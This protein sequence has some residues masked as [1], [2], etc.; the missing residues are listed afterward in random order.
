MNHTLKRFSA[1]V[2]SAV[3]VIGSLA[4]GHVFAAD[5]E[6][7]TVNIYHTNDTHSRVDNFAK[8]AA[9]V[10]NDDSD[11]AFLFD[12]GDTLHGQLF[13][14]LTEGAGIVEVMNAVGYDAMTTGNHDYNF[15]HERLK[16]LEAMMNFPIL[17]ANV[18][19]NNSVY[20]DDTAVIERNGIKVGVFGLAT[21][22]TK[23]KAHPDFTRGLDFGDLDSIV[24]DAQRAIDRLERQD[25]DIIVGLAHL[26]IDDA[27]VEK[28]TT[29]ADQLEGLDLLID[30]HSHS[31][32][33]DYEEFNSTH[34]TQIVSTGGYFEG[35]LGQVTIT[36][37]A[38]NEIVDLTSQLISADELAA[39]ES[40]AEVQAIIDRVNTDIEPLKNEV[41][42]TTPV[43]L[44]GERNVVR[45]GH[46]NLG[47]LLCDAMIAE[48]GADI[49]ITNGGGIRAS[50]PAGD[51]TVGQVLTVLPFGNTLIS[52][53]LTGQQ[54]K[55]T[56]NFGLKVGEGVFS[57]FS[58]MDVTT[59]IVD[60]N[61]V[62]TH[63]VVDITINGE[64][65]DMDATY[66]VAT[67]D[68]MAA[69][70][71]GYTEFGPAPEVGVYGTLDEVLTKYLRTLTPE[72]IEAYSNVSHLTSEVVEEKWELNEDGEWTYGTGTKWVCSTKDVWYYVV[73]GVMQRSQY[74][75]TDGIDYWVN[76][77]G[78]WIR[79]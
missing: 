14:T 64:P 63:Q 79:G 32:T 43:D 2:F 30:G 69:G 7:K 73:D 22:E 54:I 8:V 74:I 58:G 77:D 20:F 15:G 16:E 33:E 28:A 25:C 3:M 71:D 48:S 39:V 37:D 70:G 56:L 46:S 76:E 72:Q 38:D 4:G 36:L 13:A 47:Y 19:R 49:A 65:M 66:I 60:V 44:V 17:A 26:G 24:R 11:A 57:H 61:G 55:D 75:T 35:G 53:E 50:I 62:Q 41:I 51:I 1:L 21:P 59:Q 6:T 12:A 27:T 10:K 67:N 23:V 42:A 45:F 34:E 5:E 9:I 40:D 31:Y 18:K 29:V 78:A 68:F 52:K